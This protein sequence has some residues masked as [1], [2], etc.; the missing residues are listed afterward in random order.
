[1]KRPRK[2]SK[3]KVVKAIARERVGTPKPARLV[4]DKTLRVKPKHKKKILEED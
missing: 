4:E 1:V 2:Y 3:T